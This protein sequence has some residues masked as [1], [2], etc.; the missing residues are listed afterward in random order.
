MSAIVIYSIVLILV[1]PP[2]GAYMYRVY[3][4]ER[5][6]RIEGVIYRLIGVDPTVEQSWRRYGAGVLWFS[7][8][9]MLLLYVLFR[10][11][12]AL[13]LNPLGL[14]GVDTYVSFNTASS[15]VTNTNWQAYGGEST[16]SYLSQMLGL[17][18]QNFVSAAAGMAVLIAMVRGFPEHTGR[19]SGSRPNGLLVLHPPEDEATVRE[20]LPRLNGQGIPTDL[21]TPEEITTEWPAFDLSGIGLGAHELDAGASFDIASYFFSAAAIDANLSTGSVTGEGTDTLTGIE[22][23]EGSRDDTLTG[24]EGGNSFMPGDGD[25]IID[26]GGGLTDEVS[27]FYSANAVTVDLGGGTAT[28]EGT[29]SITGIESFYGSPFDDTIVGDANPNELWGGAGD[30]QP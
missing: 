22:V 3:T 1:T 23:L 5:I 8:F 7:L 10:L 17:T 14:P 29:D 18:F 16:M 21:L 20:V 28:G 9:G 4:R 11:Q 12:G 30:K 15:F 26:G 6:G 19:E 25:D 27:Y 24:D 2:L 13:P